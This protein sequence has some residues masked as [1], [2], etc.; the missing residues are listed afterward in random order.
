MK[1]VSFK[2]LLTHA[3]KRESLAKFALLLT[4]L[5]GYFIYLS[6]EFGLATG[7]LV[8]ALTWSF[9]VL[10]TP[11]ADA[12]FLLDFPVRL[13]TGMKMLYCEILVWGLA[14]IINAIALF[15]SPESYQ[16]SFLTSLLYKIITTPLPYWGIILLSCVGTFLSIR[17]GDEMMDVINHK[18]RDFHHKH[19]FKHRIILI[20]AFALLAIWAYYHLIGTLDIHIPEL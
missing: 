10:C 4:I 3:P 17:F 13:I 18:N 12:G 14:F 20:A 5:V 8:A 19:S 9:F 6:L 11:I 15:F 7:G 2:N 16:S 1:N